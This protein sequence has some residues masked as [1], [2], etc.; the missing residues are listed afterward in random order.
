[1][2]WRTPTGAPTSTSMPA[3]R[4]TNRPASVPQVTS[5]RAFRTALPGIPVQR[6]FHLAE[7]FVKR[8]F[9]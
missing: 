4:A 3:L 8:F 6:F 2:T 7:I 1:M 5:M 9:P